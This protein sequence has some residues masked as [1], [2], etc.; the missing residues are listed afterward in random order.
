MT[1]YLFIYHGGGVP[2]TPEDMEAVFK[3]WQD[4]LDALGDAV[5]DGGNPVGESSTVQSDGTVV[6]DG[7]ANPASGYGIFAAESREAAIEMAKSCPIL[8][9]GGTVE[10][11]DIFQV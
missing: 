9:G 3:A 1:N 2:E 10:L 11:A 7:G 8:A 5:V 4:W 6:N